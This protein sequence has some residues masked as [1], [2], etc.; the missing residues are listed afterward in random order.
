MEKILVIED[1]EPQLKLLLNIL[2]DAGFQAVG[3][4]DGLEA[5]EIYRREQ[6]EFDLV[7]SD[8]ALPKLGGWT[9]Y[10]MLK[11]INPNLKM[12]LTSGYLD[13]K[14]KDDLVRGGVKD[15]IPKP[16]LPEKIVTSVKQ[17]LKSP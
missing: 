1:E 8:M 6:G 15:F 11:E 4:K 16:Y 13:A 17:A 9:V 7:L 3:A 10:L 14:V 12:I 5:R 2:Q